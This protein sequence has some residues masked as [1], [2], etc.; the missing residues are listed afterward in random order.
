MTVN[1]LP[2]NLSFGFTLLELLVALAVLGVALAAVVGALGQGIDMTVA[3]RDR[4]I[5]RWVAEDRLA[6]H[7]LVASWPE[8]GTYEGTS[9]MAGQT[10]WWREQVSTTTLPELLRLDIEVRTSAEAET[11]AH[12]VGFLRKPSS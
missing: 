10:W 5:G 11:L 1:R 6:Y 2:E 9:E 4:T 3:L 7:R 8:L 12:L